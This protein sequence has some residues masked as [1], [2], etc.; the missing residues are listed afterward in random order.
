MRRWT[1][2]IPSS[3]AGPSRSTADQVR[4]SETSWPRT[5]LNCPHK[6]TEQRRETA[7][8]AIAQTDSA[9]QIAMLQ[10]SVTGFVRGAMDLQKLRQCRM[11]L[12]GFDMQVTKEMAE[13]GWFSI[14]VPETYDGLGLG[15]A[16]LS[17]V[18]QELG[19]GL[20]AEPLVASAVLAGRVL[21]HGT[22]ESLKARLLPKLADASLL[23][24]V[25]WQE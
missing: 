2:S 8:Q 10:E 7:M 15:F 13:L 17:V 22:N 5:F 25:A 3:T 6:V 24:I 12:P 18:L 14:L 20:L 19:K 11:T 9:E 23:P 16:E 4:C 21:H 1:F